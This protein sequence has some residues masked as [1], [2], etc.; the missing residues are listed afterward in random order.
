MRRRKKQLDVVHRWEGNPIITTEDIPSSCGDIYNSAAVKFG[1]TYLLLLD[2]EDQKGRQAIYIG[3]SDNGY[4]FDIEKTPFLSSDDIPDGKTYAAYGVM[5]PRITFLE[6]S[7]YI[8]Y[9]VN[10]ALGFRLALAKTNDFIKVTHINYISEPD[11]KAGALFPEKI[12]GRYA[13]LERPKSGGRI[14]ISYSDDLIFWGDSKV[15]MSPRP[16]FWDFHR[17]GCAIPPFRIKNRNWLLIY[18][19]IKDTVSG[20]LF[21]IGAAILDKDT[22]SKI[23]SRTNIPLLSPRELHERI[24]DVNNLIY[25]CGAILEDDDTLKIYY[26]A[27][28]SCICIGTIKIGKIIENCIESKREF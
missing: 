16:G 1:N 5:D 13:R 20:P 7:Y 12:K 18:Y 2:I 10:S 6:G 24:G 21:R 4:H 11:T 22:P 3:R 28:H 25:T 27:A 26:G 8:V 23:I 15:L 9:M 17:I 14:W 19:G